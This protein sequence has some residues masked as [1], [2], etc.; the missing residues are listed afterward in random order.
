M[1]VTGTGPG[2]WSLPGSGWDGHSRG[3][4]HTHGLSRG[5][6]A[7]PPP[8]TVGLRPIEAIGG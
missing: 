7:G 2:A 3:Q 8:V 1:T 4:G 5:A 6:A